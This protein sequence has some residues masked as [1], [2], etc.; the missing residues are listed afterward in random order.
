MNFSFLASTLLYYLHKDDTTANQ[1][2]RKCGKQHIY[3]LQK[4]QIWQSN[5]YSDSHTNHW[6]P[7]IHTAT[8]ATMQC[9][10][11]QHKREWNSYVKKICMWCKAH[12]YYIIGFGYMVTSSM[13]IVAVTGFSLQRLAAL[14]E[15]NRNMFYFLAIGLWCPCSELVVLRVTDFLHE[16]CILVHYGLVEPSSYAKHLKSTINKPR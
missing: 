16:N 10:A 13:C 7:P 2:A 9:T 11:T 8:T 14:A 6:S 4:L 1:V 15:K 12:K 5:N 3:Y